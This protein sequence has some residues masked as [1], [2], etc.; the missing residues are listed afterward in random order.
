M[1]HLQPHP[2]HFRALVLYVILAGIL[3]GGMAYLLLHDGMKLRKHGVEGIAIAGWTSGE[4]QTYYINDT[5]VNFSTEGGTGYRKAPCGTAV[6][7]VYLLD[8][9]QTAALRRKSDSVVS[10]SRT[11][12]LSLWFVFILRM[13]QL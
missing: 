12:D 11:D 6:A 1:K 4:S 10:L 9:P 5:E 7:I 3:F 13:F 8:H 2:L